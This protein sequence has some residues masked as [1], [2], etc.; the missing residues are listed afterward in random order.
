[1]NYIEF[2]M[3]TGKTHNAE[4]EDEEEEDEID[5]SSAPKETPPPPSVND[6]PV[7][8]LHIIPPPKKEEVPPFPDATHHLPKRDIPP[9]IPDIN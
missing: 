2:D 5:T 4:K 6:L 1:M 3:Q 8:E 7:P 9:Q